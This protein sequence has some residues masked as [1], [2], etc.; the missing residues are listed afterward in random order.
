[1]VTMPA[2][3]KAQESQTYLLSTAST[4]GTYYPVGVAIANLIKVKLQQPMGISLSAISSAGS[5]ENVKLLRERQVEFAILQGIFGVWAWRGEGPIAVNGPQTHLRGVTMLWQNIEHFVLR[6]DMVQSGDLD[7]LRRGENAIVA[8]GN[9]NSGS[10]SSNNFIFDTLGIT[11]GEDVTPAF[12]GYGQG[13]DALRNGTAHGM[14]APAGVPV[15]AVTQAFASLGGD[16][17]LLDISDA[18]MA[19]LNAGFD[20]WARHVLPANTY[21]GQTRDV[22]SLAMP[23]VLAVHEDVAEETVYQITKTI[24]ENLSFLRAI[25][26]AT[27]EMSIERAVDHMPIPLHPGALRYYR[28]VGL[29]IPAGL[30]AE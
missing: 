12:L 2:G 22:R 20:L 19:S 16:L 23:N 13:A 11:R 24:Y 7:D 8:V 14:S 1:M 18:D 28:E 6:S 15:G 30:V 9:R 5:A 21:P 3:L 26:R 29:E 10:E 4:G 25:H 27:A 17:T